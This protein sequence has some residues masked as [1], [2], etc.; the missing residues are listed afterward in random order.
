MLRI[1]SQP[2]RIFTTSVLLLPFVARAQFDTVVAPEGTA[3]GELIPAIVGIINVAL[4]FVGILAGVFLIYGGLQYI[5]SRGDERAA[6]K[7]KA[8]ILYA[9]IGLIVIGLSAAIVNFVVG[10]FR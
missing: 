10:A 3:R 9:V 4:L 1:I 6:E 5:M 8:T 7:A 2:V